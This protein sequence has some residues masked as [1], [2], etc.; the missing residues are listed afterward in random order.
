MNKSFLDVTVQKSV[1]FLILAMFKLNVDCGYQPK[2]FILIL[3]L[4]DCHLDSLAN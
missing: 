1:S 2:N 3:F 4:S